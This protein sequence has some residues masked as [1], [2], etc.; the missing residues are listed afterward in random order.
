MKFNLKTDLELI[1]SQKEAVNKITKNLK[2]KEK[3]NVLLGV[4]GCGKT[5][6]MANVI[7]K[8]QKPTLVISH[9]KTLAAQ[10]YQEFKDFFPEN[11]VHYFVSYY[12]Y[13]QPEAYIPQT[14]TYIAKDAKIN[15]VIDRLRHEATQGILSRNDTIIVASVSCIYNI[16][17]PENYKNISFLIKKDQKIQRKELL[18]N[19]IKLQYERNEIDFSAGKFRVRGNIVEIF[20]PTGEEIIKIELSTNEISKIFLNGNAKNPDGKFSEIKKYRFFPA[21]FW[22]T[23]PD[24]NPLAISSIK[25]ELDERLKELKKQK[26]L[27]E[28]KRLERQ[29]NYDIEMIK[30]TGWCSGIENYSRHFEF[31]EP[32]SP[33]F[34]LL[35]Y[36]PGDF[37]IL[38][39]E[40]HMTIPQ[41]YSMYRG[42]KARKETLVEYGFRLP[43][44]LDNRPLKFEEFEKKINQVSYISATPGKYEIEKI[45][46]KKQKLLT[47]VLIR[48]TG[49]LDPKIEIRTTENQIENLISEVQKAVDK[50]ERVLVTTLT[51]RLAED[52]SDYLEEKGFK[53]QYLHSEVKTLERPGILRDLREGK[54][55]ILV[56]INL[57]REGLDLPEVALI[58][59]L[60]ADKEGF[61]RNE[62]T[63][64]QTMGRAARHPNGR[65][66]MYADEITN[67]MKNAIKETER[68]RKIQEKHNKEN[69]ITPQA[70]KKAIREWDFS[71]AK[72]EITDISELA[73]ITDTNFLKK[74][75]QKAA[76]EL[77][78]ERAARIRDEIKKIEK[79]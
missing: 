79:R 27:F 66:I 13:Y 57:L 59:I 75:M 63:L 36:Y 30:E 78:F 14:D 10:L 1:K 56:G 53:V 20:S 42:D 24:K 46:S 50:K 31:R 47:E 28:A 34:S 18:K 65:I 33:P 16:G 3:H 51:K 29:V 23:P 12:D 37:L 26:K 68:R 8:I 39:D 54:Y 44:A 35:D 15:D 77:N 45:K 21:K 52:L 4:T 41:L 17:S 62:T 7:E 9:N 73:K 70:I 6:I 64:V 40:S 11:S 19:L 2:E 32:G 49:L 22:V 5:F 69:N 55:D 60:D 43:S 74:E 61:L 76:Q 58:A 72:K 25:L 71:K 48:P 38:I 67:S